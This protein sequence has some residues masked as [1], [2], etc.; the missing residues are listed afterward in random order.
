L[1]KPRAGIKKLNPVLFNIKT[2]KQCHTKQELTR[3]RAR[4][5]KQTEAIIFAKKQNR[6]DYNNKQAALL[7]NKKARAW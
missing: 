7:R 6:I 3:S 2:I 5:S 1:G 4:P